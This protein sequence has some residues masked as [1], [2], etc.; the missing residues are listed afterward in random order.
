M[1]S[2]CWNWEFYLIEAFPPLLPFPLCIKFEKWLPVLMQGRQTW[3]WSAQTWSQRNECFGRLVNYGSCSLVLELKCISRPYD[4]KR[5]C[6]IRIL[7]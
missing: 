6:V 4:T 1:I 5:L 7:S 2:D 3:R